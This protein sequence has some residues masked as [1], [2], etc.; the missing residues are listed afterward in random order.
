MF[1]ND[2]YLGSDPYLQNLF[3]KPFRCP[4]TGMPNTMIYSKD[5]QLQHLWML[6]GFG[7]RRFS[8]FTPSVGCRA[9]FYSG[10]LPTVI[11][12]MTVRPCIQTFI[13]VGLY[14]GFCNRWFIR[15]YFISVF[16]IVDGFILLLHGM[17]LCNNVLLLLIVK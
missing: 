7:L 4:A 5:A 10:M 2:F 8:Y 13:Q 16:Y 12:F 3:P 6:A 9:V 11:S 14:I 1:L 15:Y 17:Y